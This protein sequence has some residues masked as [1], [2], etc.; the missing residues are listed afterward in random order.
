MDPSLISL[1]K[2][3]L[4]LLILDD[5]DALCTEGIIFDTD[6]EIED[7]ACVLGGS[8][9]GKRPNIN[10][11]RQLF[12]KLLHQDYFAENA[13]Y[14]G[15]H[16]R[17]RFRM[18]RQLFLRIV[19][20]V[21]SHDQYFTQK[22]DCTGLLGF[23]AI[24]KCAAAVRLLASGTSADEMDDRYRLAESTMLETLRRF[25]VSVIEIYGDQYLRSPCEE[26]LKQILRLHEK[27]DGRECW[28]Q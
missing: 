4:E 18:T 3:R 16:F 22:R 19:Q 9:P 21:E 10:R 2:R 8:Q 28:G 13:T 26:D 5:D 14:S 6:D 20:A 24:Q 17:R 1:W 7:D 15:Q 12:G 23:T 11:K 25:C 27:K